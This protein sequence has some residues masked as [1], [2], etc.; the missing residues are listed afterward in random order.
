MNYKPRE[1]RNRP[2]SFL[3]A[4]AHDRRD[5]LARRLER[6]NRFLTRRSQPGIGHE[7]AKLCRLLLDPHEFMERLMSLMPD[8]PNLKPEP[9]PA[10]AKHAA[11]LARL[12][13]RE[14]L[15]KQRNRE[16]GA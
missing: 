10:S 12:D 6:T 11:A 1:S 4:S 14:R 13:E 8:R 5:V 2:I 16:Y 3:L 7:I 9:G 15:N